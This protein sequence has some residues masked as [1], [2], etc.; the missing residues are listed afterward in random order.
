MTQ[1]SDKQET[2]LIDGMK[3]LTLDQ[4]PELQNL[5]DI[6]APPLDAPEAKYKE[7]RRTTPTTT[8]MYNTTDQEVK[9]QHEEE[10]YGIYMS[11]FG[12]KGDDSDLDSD[13]DSDSNMI[14]YLFLE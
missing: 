7:Q 8:P 13:T 11:T 6:L 9:L 10:R 4:K 5:T 2:D 14:A 3:D 1:D 12:Y